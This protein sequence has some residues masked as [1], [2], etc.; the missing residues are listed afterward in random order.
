MGTMVVLLLR[1][2]RREPDRDDDDTSAL[3]V[4]DLE[5]RDE[6]L[7]VFDKFSV[8]VACSP[9]TRPV[10]MESITSGGR[11]ATS[12]QMERVSLWATFT[13][14]PWSLEASKYSLFVSEATN[15]LKKGG[16]AHVARALW[17]YNKVSY[18]PFSSCTRT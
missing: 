4:V 17:M 9:S 15:G 18:R 2:G 1:F 10:P 11:S 13:G 16:A 6:G 3:V 12:G 5:E 14:H 8:L 7:V